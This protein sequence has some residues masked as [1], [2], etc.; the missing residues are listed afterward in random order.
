MHNHKLAIRRRTAQS[1]ENIQAVA[2]SISKNFNESL[3][4]RS[5][6]LRPSTMTMQRNLGLYPYK[7]VLTQQLNPSDHQQRRVFDNRAL[8][9]LANNANSHQKIIFSK[10]ALLC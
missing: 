2:F 10:E 5:Y 8:E 6:T 1:K 9:R 7:I 3:L 4:Q